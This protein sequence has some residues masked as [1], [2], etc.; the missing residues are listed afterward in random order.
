MKIVA[1]RILSDRPDIELDEDF[2]VEFGE[3]YGAIAVAAHD[4]K[5]QVYLPR[6]AAIRVEPRAA[7]LVWVAHVPPVT[8]NTR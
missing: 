5:V 8:F 4:G 3:G 6:G 1:K 2:I 7:N